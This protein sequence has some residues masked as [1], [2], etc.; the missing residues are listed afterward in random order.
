MKNKLF[1][2]R[3]LGLMSL[4]VVAPMAHAALTTGE[5]AYTRNYSLA[6]SLMFYSSVEDAWK[7]IAKEKHLSP[8]IA[9]TYVY[10]TKPLSDLQDQLDG[11]SSIPLVQKKDLPIDNSSL[12]VAQSRLPAQDNPAPEIQAK[13]RPQVQVAPVRLRDELPTSAVPH[14]YQSRI[15]AVDAQALNFGRLVP[16]SNAKATW[17]GTDSRLQSNADSM[18]VIKAPYPRTRSQRFIVNADGYIPAVGYVVMGTVSIAPMY[19]A[20][21]VK[22]LVETLGINAGDKHIVLGKT[23]DENL[24]PLANVKVELSQGDAHVDYS[25]SAWGLFTK[26]LHQSGPAGDFVA[27]G[28][29]SEIQYF[30]PV[31]GTEEWPSTSINFADLPQVVSIAL[32]RAHREFARTNILDGFTL[33]KPEGLVTLTIGGQRGVYIPEDVAIENTSAESSSENV[34]TNTLIENLFV[35]PAINIFEVRA[36]SYLKTWVS[37]PTTPNLVSKFTPVLSEGQIQSIL[38]PIGMNWSSAESI[39]LTSVS[40]KD[41]G[42]KPMKLS[43]LD[44]EGHVVKDAQ[45]IYFDQQKQASTEVASTKYNNHALIV[46]LEAGEY[47]V[48]AIDPSASVTQKDG[49]QKIRPAGLGSTVIQT[50]EGVL[51]YF[52]I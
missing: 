27:T 8:S 42:N 30:M 44:S 16:L 12:L 35:R 39:V 9:E 43:V 47:N 50:S 38:A 36:P 19:K 49:S 45:I 10:A 51:T 20:D 13:A 23:L 25:T 4:L 33:E 21:L 28:L 34:P 48:V 11:E 18:G 7:L 24:H 37:N 46:G 41:Y 5:P 40:T 1:K 6:G 22:P 26:N 3:Y 29:D 17:I 2:S 31:E 15:L 32:P 14:P 52:E